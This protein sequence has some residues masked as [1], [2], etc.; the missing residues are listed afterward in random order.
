MKFDRVIGTGGIGTGVFF[1]LS[2]NA[3]LGREESRGGILTDYKDYCKLHIILSYVGRLIGGKIPVCAVGKVGRDAAGEALLREMES[4]GIGCAHVE[5]A[6]NAPTTY[7]VCFQYPDNSGC[8]VTAENGAS[9]TVDPAFIERALESLAPDGKTLALA[10]PE[11]PL[12]ARKRFIEICSSRGA[13]V[14]A[15]FSCEELR[16]ESVCDIL[17]GVS[18]LSVN[19]EEAAALAGGK[20]TVERCVQKAVSCNERAEVLITDGG[21]GS[22][23]YSGGTLQKFC[24]AESAVVST[25]GAGDSFLGGV[26]VGKCFS[27]P[28]VKD[29][30]DAYFGQ[31]PLCTATELGILASHF[32]V[33]SAD[34]IPK[35][36]SAEEILR[37]LARTGLRAPQIEKYLQGE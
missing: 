17:R 6:Q 15:S 8:N 7:S 3:T 34:T 30:E 29:R 19:M 25:A 28:L 27:L 20:D 10:A 31:T 26:M 24:A 32:A 2:G 22:Y 4:V 35:K 1:R 21:R 11:V 36:F 13:F 37:Y 5:K 23:A 12:E 16:S 9:G 33:E 18:L 14:A